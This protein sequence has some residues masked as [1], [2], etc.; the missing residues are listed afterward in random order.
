MK[1]HRN[2]PSR[3]SFIRTTALGAGAL[4]TAP[5]LFRTGLAAAPPG[6]VEELVALG[7]TGIKASFLAQGTG[8]NGYNQTSAQTRAGKESFDRL[9]RTSLD[10]G[11]NFM[12]MADLY[13]SH[14]FV[15]DVVKGIPRDRMVMLSKIWP[16]KAEWNEPSGGAFA[17]VERFLKELNTDRLEI[18]LIHCMTNDRWATEYEQIREELTTLKQQGKVRAVGVSCHDF[19]ALK[20]A[21]EHPWVDVILARINHKG[22]RD[23]SCDASV[24]ELTPVLKQ[25]RANGKVVIGMKIFGAGKLTSPEDKDASLKFVVQNG[26]VDAITIGTTDPGQVE[27]TVTRVNKALAA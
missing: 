15:R 5:S 1:T 23:Y 27:D 13:G 18:C 21:A 3:R 24:E 8:Y 9:V 7:K 17:E 26:L 12:D 4:V 25:A 11:V 2:H 10:R 20:V 6:N 14:P 16:R 22:G 19:G